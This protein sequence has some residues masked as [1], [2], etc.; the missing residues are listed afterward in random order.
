MYYRYACIFYFNSHQPRLFSSIK[1]SFVF[2]SMDIALD[3]AKHMHRAIFF[4]LLNLARL[5]F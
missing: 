3:A 5:A 2:S 4:K 1:K